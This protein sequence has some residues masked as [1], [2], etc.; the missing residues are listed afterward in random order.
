M[1]RRILRGKMHRKCCRKIRRKIRRKFRSKF[2]RKFRGKVL[3]EIQVFFNF[4]FLFTH[5]QAEVCNGTTYIYHFFDFV[6]SS[7]FE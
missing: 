1:L 7:D 5:I 6:N 2:L 3:F 4:A